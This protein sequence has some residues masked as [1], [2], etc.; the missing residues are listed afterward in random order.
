[1]DCISV[2]LS[3]VSNYC[4][5]FVLIN[6]IVFWKLINWLICENNYIDR[7]KHCTIIRNRTGNIRY[8]WYLCLTW[9]HRKEMKVLTLYIQF[10]VLQKRHTTRCTKLMKISKSYILQ[11]D[12]NILLLKMGKREEAWTIRRWKKNHLGI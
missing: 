2:I 9:N 7:Y 4:A 11:R 8:Q 10:R 12:R 6:V 3:L 5:M 1:M